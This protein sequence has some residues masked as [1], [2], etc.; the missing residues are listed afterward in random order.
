MSS[1]HYLHPPMELPTEEGRMSTERG[2]PGQHQRRW[3]TVLLKPAA[4]SHTPR[5]DDDEGP[6]LLMAATGCPQLLRWC[7]GCHAMAA[8]R[9][10]PDP[11]RR[12]LPTSPPPQ[13]PVSTPPPLPRLATF[14]IDLFNSPEHADYSKSQ[15]K[16]SKRKG[17][18]IC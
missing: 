3:P 11:P 1:S 9:G 16:A 2:L 13:D 7:R 18:E 6:P 10:T 5:A 8:P 15:S 4:M 12:H 14:H 17:S